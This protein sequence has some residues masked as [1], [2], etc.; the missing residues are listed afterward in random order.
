MLD[1]PTG[2]DICQRESVPALIS[3]SVTRSGNRTRIAVRVLEAGGGSLLYM[4]HAEY[5]KP[6]ELFA[7]VDDLARDLRE[8]LGESLDAIAS[9]SQPLQKVTTGSLEALRQDLEVGRGP[10]DGGV[11]RRR[12]AAAGRAAARPAT[13]RWPT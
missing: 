1:E 11:R 8:H 4:G 12:S 13:S 3:G 6:E 10:G 5:Q 9:S 7:R 2:R